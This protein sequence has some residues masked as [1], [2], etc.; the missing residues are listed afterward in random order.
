V[1]FVKQQHR[2]KVVMC[3]GEKM[4]KSDLEKHLEE[5]SDEELTDKVRS[6]YY[7]ARNLEA[8]TAEVKRRG[9]VMP[10]EGK[11]KK[12]ESFIKRHPVWALVIAGFAAKIVIEMI[13]RAMH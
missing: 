8:V 9:L 13:K 1:F 11:S 4:E 5:I 10:D 12:N 6:N 3:S 7:D 2:L